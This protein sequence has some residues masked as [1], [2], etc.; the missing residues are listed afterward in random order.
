MSFEIGERVVFRSLLWEVE[1]TSSELSLG[2]FGRSAENQGRHVRV[3]LE[4]DDISRAELPELR[5]TIGTKGWDVRQ[6]KALHDAFRF[7]LSH[8]RG[9]LASVDW[10]RLVL[11]PYQ[12]EPLRKI[13][14]LPFPRLLIGDDTGLGKTAEAGL[15][16]SRLMQKRRADRVLI[17]CRA[18]PEPER[19]QREMRD[20]FGI[21]TLVINDQDDFKRLCQKVPAHLNPF[22]YY[23]RIVMSMH[24]AAQT[25]VMD[26]LR[27][28]V[29]WDI[30]I[31]DEAH[32]VA[33][34]EGSKKQLADLG[35]VV[36]EKS[37]ALLLLTATPHD[38][39]TST[40]ASL[41]RLL[42]PY[43]V[44]DPNA[45]DV[46]I[47]RP[48]VV[49]RLK[50]E[51]EKADGTRFQQ[52][53][54]HMLDIT[55]YRK[56]AERALDKGIADY[57]A[58]LK[59]HA[60]HLEQQGQREQAFGAAFLGTFFK[61]RL[62]SSV[63]ACRRS[64]Q[65][66]LATVHNKGKS[67]VSADV[68]SYMQLAFDDQIASG[69]AVNDATPSTEGMEGFVFEGGESEEALLQQ[70]LQLADNVKEQQESKVQ[71]LLDLLQ[72][73]LEK[74]A[75]KV[76]IFTE[77][78]DTLHML[79]HILTEHGYGS[80]LVTY[81]GA[82][83]PAERDQHRRAFLG[84]PNV[85][86][87]LA[88]DA[89]SEGI[90]LHKSCNTLIHVEIPWNPNRYEQRNGRIDRYGQESKP[91]IFLLLSP[92][93]V[94]QRVAEVVV[95]KLERIRRELGSV[96]NVFPM[97]QKLKLEQFLRDLDTS[98][99]DQQEQLLSDEA[100]LNPAIEAVTAQVEQRLDQLQ[101]EQTTLPSELMQGERFGHE[102]ML[103]L[104]AQLDASRAFVPE[105]QDIEEFL[106]VFLTLSEINDG[107]MRPAHEHG[108]WSVDIPERLRRELRDVY[109]QQVQRYPRATFQRQLAIQEAEREVEQRVEFLSPGHPFVQSALRYMRGRAFR[110]DFPSRIAYRRMPAGSQSGYLFTYAVRFVDGRGETLEERFEV[111]FVALDGTVSQDA[112]ADLRLFTERRPFGNLSV[113]EEQE[114]LPLFQ[115]AFDDARNSAFAE[116]Q[117][118]RDERCRALQ[119][120][121]EQRIFDALEKLGRWKLA[122]EIQLHQRFKDVQP[123]GHAPVQLRLETPEMRRR[124]TLLTREEEKLES[125]GQERRRDIEAMKEVRG[126][127]IDSIGVLVLIPAAEKPNS[128]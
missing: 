16:L 75:E 47:I 109:R 40:Y 123:V 64:L 67:S 104:Q 128:P 28:D 4:L 1:D 115:A 95:E 5:W 94:E 93:S 55:K 57:A 48:L 111:V 99:I 82:T 100:S 62:S 68:D 54:I 50:S 36:A 38:G 105:Y 7:T 108:V 29:R 70:L 41:I 84:N 122:N 49:R 45:L 2:L 31:I 88:T 121:Q 60:Q 53:E 83:P 25:H 46:E 92:R 13:E 32:H 22:S 73:I 27:R 119:R 9:N 77:F 8:A 127:S 35:R 65:E 118:R 21:E 12:L 51:V 80:M 56:K 33:E 125:K 98:A 18:Q 30:A 114:V 43:A 72:R 6:W 44:T 102:E 86:I 81:H 71:A 15:I 124:K 69:D 91:Q 120:Q 85:R 52:R 59:T 110:A 42:D 3:L 10:G 90:N 112:E 87:F 19:W 126:E 89:A 103:A 107:D 79:E 23:S 74:P 58:R 116:M 101:Q 14:E 106:R 63:F 76:V 113:Q 96:A 61:K 26:D 34:R 117:H 39:K 11:E 66:R 20:K 97:T 37:E 24:Y 78:R 17:L